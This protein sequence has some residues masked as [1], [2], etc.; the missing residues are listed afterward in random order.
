[1]E[2]LEKSNLSR[3]DVEELF[4][5]PETR[6]KALRSARGRSRFM[7]TLEGMSSQLWQAV[8]SRGE[9]L[10]I[11]VEAPARKQVMAHA[12]LS[13][14]YVRGEEE[15]RPKAT[16]PDVQ[17][18]N[19]TL[20]EFR[21]ENY[22]EETEWYLRE[23]VLADG[24][25]VG[26]SPERLLQYYEEKYPDSL[27]A[28]GIRIGGAI[29]TEKSGPLGNRAAVVWKR[30]E[31]DKAQLKG[32]TII[33]PPDAGLV[34]TRHEIEH[35]LDVIHGYDPSAGEYRELRDGGIAIGA[36]KHGRFDHKFFNK[37]DYLHRAL[38]RDA[39]L[40]GEQVSEE[41]LAQYK[42]DPAIQELLRLSPL[43]AVSPD[44]A[45]SEAAAPVPEKKEGAAAIYQYLELHDISENPTDAELL[46]LEKGEELDVDIINE[47]HEAIHKEVDTL[48]LGPR[49][50][51]SQ[52]LLNRLSRA[53]LNL[54]DA[55]KEAKAKRG[56]AAAPVEV[57]QEMAEI[58]QGL[59][60]IG[61]VGTEA[62]QVAELQKLIEQKRKRGEPTP[63]EPTAREEKAWVKKAREEDPEFDKALE[64]L[65]KETQAAKEAGEAEAAAA[66]E[67]GKEARSA[68]DEAMDKVEK[69]MQAAMDELEDIAGGNEAELDRLAAEEKR[70]QKAAE[71]A[72]RTPQAYVNFLAA[73][74]QR[75]SAGWGGDFIG[76]LAVKAADFGSIDDTVMVQI[77]KVAHAL[78]DQAGVNI[79]EF[80]IEQL[81]TWGERYANP[82]AVPSRGK[83][84]GRGF[85][86]NTKN[87]YAI[88]GLHPSASEAQIAKAFRGAS[89]AYHP[90]LHPEDPDATS[91]MQR[92]REAKE[93]LEEESGR[94]EQKRTYPSA[95]VLSE[96]AKEARKEA[97]PKAAPEKAPERGEPKPKEV[98]QEVTPKPA[99]AERVRRLPATAAPQ[100][101][102][103]KRGD[104]VPQTTLKLT[105]RQ[106]E[107]FDEIVGGYPETIQEISV[108]HPKETRDEIER[109][110]NELD[111]KILKVDFG[112]EAGK[113]ILGGIHGVVEAEIDM[114]STG[115]WGG[116]PQEISGRD[117]LYHNLKD[118]L[119]KALGE[120]WVEEHRK[121]QAEVTDLNRPAAPKAAEPKKG[122]RMP[123]ILEAVELPEEVKREAA[124]KAAPFKKKVQEVEDKRL[125][126]WEEG[127]PTLEELKE[128]SIDELRT[129]V[130]K[131][132]GLMK[133][134]EKWEKAPFPLSGKG[135]TKAYLASKLAAPQR[136]NIMVGQSVHYISEGEEV[137]PSL[138]VGLGR[139]VVLVKG[140]VETRETIID[141]NDIVK[142]IHG[143]KAFEL[144][145]DGGVIEILF[146]DA[147]EIAEN[148]GRDGKKWRETFE[149]FW[150]YYAPQWADW[151]QKIR[152]ERWYRQYFNVG[153]LLGKDLHSQLEMLEGKTAANV[154]AVHQQLAT[155][156]RALRKSSWAEGI[157][158][159]DK[160]LRNLS[161]EKKKVL[162]GILKIPLEEMDAYS[163]THNLPEGV[164]PVAKEIRKRINSLSRDLRE[165]FES[166][167]DKKLGLEKKYGEDLF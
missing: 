63:K 147:E 57:D 99:P 126:V 85:D 139:G 132:Y 27:G 89:R 30:D 12:K 14:T 167:V 29:E 164:V 44:L 114:I 43:L 152:K 81:R 61:T 24:T 51:E 113:I 107:A 143:G 40:E 36:E 124:K 118:K 106:R 159:R 55:A 161:N 33:L 137:G 17:I 133:R 144:D 69:M 95:V 102:E 100:A 151:G 9:E 140:N 66:R 84:A 129:M 80:S 19:M 112:S 101:A 79:D 88:L 96:I 83:V 71:E 82:P 90:D 34:V 128:L 108:D 146:S 13:D 25:K 141:R 130:R 78:E 120:E 148:G 77:A 62:E 58:D 15:N 123:R 97:P 145:N 67:E 122:D 23:K 149:K 1:M 20:E 105:K 52:E 150:L 125:S 39:L 22:Q 166:D 21:K 92:V 91:N 28:L 98:V 134:G 2:I 45:T 119:E 117:R 103:L 135:V 32:A 155:L 7:G 6:P 127:T 10:G 4:P 163:K 154:E 74:N 158:K 73:I 165:I 70:K 31:E 68:F 136:D 16:K 46:G 160:V 86:L 72:G 104:K 115:N 75:D 60:E 50:K 8:K 131:K 54:I 65:E 111:R 64:Q 121:F 47:K 3:K 56:E 153:G 41:V 37:A 53:R 138:V 110:F 35:L 38:V 5:D 59:A 162:N 11:G 26:D 49:A 109:I 156:E 87:A 48:K 93:N 18:H 42:N 94:I 76:R 157:K 116:S 142:V